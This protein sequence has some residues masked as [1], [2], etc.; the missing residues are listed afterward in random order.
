MKMIPY[1]DVIAQ[2]T[3]KMSHG[4]IFLSVAGDTPNVMTIGWGAIGFYWTKPVFTAV[5]RPQ[6]HTYP[7]LQKAG[8]FTVSVPTVHPL[9]QQLAFAGSA[10]GRDINKFEGHG[11]TAAPAIHV[12]APIVAECGLHFEVKVLLTQPMTGDNM[13]EWVLDRAYPGRD[14]HTMFFGEILACYSTDE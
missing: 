5:V 13:D 2:A 8:E 3:E 14:F 1:T 10:S 7:L 4:G 11:L 6:R 9:K 12:A